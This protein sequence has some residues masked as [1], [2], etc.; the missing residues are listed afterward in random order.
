MFRVAKDDIGLSLPEGRAREGVMMAV[1]PDLMC[2]ETALQ[3]QFDGLGVICFG[4]KAEGIRAVEHAKR[5]AQSR[6]GFEEFET[7]PAHIV[8]RSLL[9]TCLI[10]LHQPFA[11]IIGRLLILG[12]LMLTEILFRIHINHTCVIFCVII[13]LVGVIR[14]IGLTMA[15]V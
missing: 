2:L 12:E 5:K 7:D 13:E 8:F 15:E 1:R 11:Y 10:C 3:R 9:N 14:T 6:Y 4:S